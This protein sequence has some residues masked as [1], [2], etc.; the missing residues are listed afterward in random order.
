MIVGAGPAGLECAV[1]LGK[2]GFEQVHVV[3]AA[4]EIGGALRWLSRLPGLDEWSRVIDYRKG[5][6]AKLANVALIPR[7]ELGP[8]DVLD[9]G[10]AIVIIATGSRWAGDGMNWATHEQTSGADEGLPHIF[11]PEQIL[12]NRQALG[13]T[14]SDRV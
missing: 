7:T 1:T 13:R 10:G 14:Q 4:R 9:Y 6:I 11:T 12:V 2:R 8:A 5:Q 3:D